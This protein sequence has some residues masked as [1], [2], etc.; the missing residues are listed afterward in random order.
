VTAS[1]KISGIWKATVPYVRVAGVW[2][3]PRNSWVKVSGAWRQWWLLGGLNDSTFTTY[4]TSNRFDN[5]VNAI[6]FQSDGKIL[7]GGL[8]T[9]F[10]GIFASRIVRLNS[11]G[12]LD[13]AFNAN[14]AVGPSGDVNALAIQSDGKI[15]VGGNFTTWNG[16]SVGR[17]VRLNSDGTQDTAFSAST[18]SAANSTVN[19]FAIQSD[20]KIVVGGAFTTWNGTTVGYIVRLNTSG[21][22]ES[23]FNTNTGTGANSSVLGLAI[24]SDGKIVIVGGFTT[25]SGTPVNRIVRLNTDGARDTVFTTNTGT[26]PNN[27]TFTVAVQSDGKIIVGGRF[28]TWQSVPSVGR[29]VRLNSN[30]TRDTA[31]TT[32]TTTAANFDILS[33][34]LQADG[35]IVLVGGF[36]FWNGVI[37]NRIVRLN[38]DGTRDTAFTTTAGLGANNQLNAVAIQPDGKIVLGGG[39]TTWN[40]TVVNRIVRLNTDATIDTSFPLNAGIGASENFLAEVHSIAVQ[41]DNKILASGNF[42]TWNSVT[43][44]CIVR[45][46]ADGT[47]DTVFTTNTGTAATNLGS[48]IYSIKVQSDGKIIACGEFALWNGGTVNRIVRLNPDGTQDTA[49]TTNTG[50]GANL[51]ALTL[52]V[53]SD[54]KILVGGQF[55]T[56]NGATV[57]RI[58][59]LNT[60]GTRDTTFTTNAGTAADSNVETIAVQSDGKIILGGAFTTWNGVTVNRIVRLNTDGTRDTTFTTNV[61]T[62]ADNRIDG[63]AIQPD[64]KILVGGQFTIWNGVTVN[65]IVRLNTDGT[66]DTTFTTNAG[67]AANSGVLTIALQS[68]GKIVVGG[69]FT[70]WSGV[71]ASRIVRLN[72]SGAR[73]AAF[74]TNTNLGFN[75]SVFVVAVQSDQD[76]LVGGNFYGYNQI[77]RTALARISGSVAA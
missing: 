34:G 51:S 26:G 36:I 9:T 3:L 33:I 69:Q 38:S 56:W 59:R 18:G 6:A 65:R 31:F 61:G 70:S 46:N 20:G 29:I 4:D 10:N 68:D 50:T 76:I 13:T 45:L 37:V 1:V 35:K 62:A 28:T 11:D 30:G 43:V 49:F 57:N 16:N 25:W 75:G 67:T 44:N 21:T 48:F 19:A 63:I 2:K 71:S 23:A 72:S 32:N 60:D 58:V 55:T 54:G 42:T 74:V 7:V 5:N 39:V 22:R 27:L 64:G 53:Q 77:N 24:Q 17:I 47:R 14:I 66:R 52:A 8:F 41:S 40:V 15:L 12:T 73:D